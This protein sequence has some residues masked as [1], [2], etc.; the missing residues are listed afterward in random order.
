[1]R[2]SIQTGNAGAVTVSR[3]RGRDGGGMGRAVVAS[4]GR[5]ENSVINLASPGAVARGGVV[6]QKRGI[7][8]LDHSIAAESQGS[9]SLKAWGSKSPRAKGGRGGYHNKKVSF[10]IVDEVSISPSLRPVLSPISF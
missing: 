2:A 3:G 5:V 6:E 1:M 8:K 9:K 7:M 4:G 10:R